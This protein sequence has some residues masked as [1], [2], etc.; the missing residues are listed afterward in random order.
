MAAQQNLLRNPAKWVILLAAAA[1]VSFT[2]QSPEYLAFK[3]ALIATETGSVTNKYLAVKD[4][5]NGEA[6]GVFQIHYAYWLD[7][8]GLDTNIVGNYEQC[9]DFAY[10][11]RV[12][13]AYLMHYGSNDIASGNW[14]R[15]ARIHNGGPY[16]V[17]KDA[18]RKFWLKVK[19]TLNGN[20]NANIY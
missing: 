12:V 16:G 8:V 10:A 15:L 17:E 1:C 11:S 19:N 14:E 4:G 7:T 20:T 2:T 3:D 5:D 6:I 13:D 9:R 18:T